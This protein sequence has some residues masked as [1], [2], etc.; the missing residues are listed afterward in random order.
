MC[1]S[2]KSQW[3]GEPY[4]AGAATS[5]SGILPQIPSSDLEAQVPVFISPRNRVA[6][7]PLGTGFPFVASYDSQGY[8]GGTLTRI[9]TLYMNTIDMS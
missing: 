3:C 6:V 7:I 9:V 4:F 1:A 5:T 8:G 2:E